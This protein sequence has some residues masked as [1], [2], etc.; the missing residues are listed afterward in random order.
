ALD[1]MSVL[2]I[3]ER[4]DLHVELA[5][6]RH[7]RGWLIRD[8]LD[9]RR[10]SFGALGGGRQ[11]RNGGARILHS[12][13]LLRWGAPLF[14]RRAGEGGL[15]SRGVRRGLRTVGVHAAR[16]RAQITDVNAR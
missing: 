6:D 2:H 13:G 12:S 5:G 14:L 11:Q 10:S 15:L 8:R 4:A 9:A 1:T 3:R 16:S 7:R